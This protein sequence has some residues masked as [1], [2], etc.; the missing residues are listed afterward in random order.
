MGGETKPAKALGYAFS[1]APNLESHH[2]MS[3]LNASGVDASHTGEA[4]PI[5]IHVPPREIVVEQP[6]VEQRAAR[7]IAELQPAGTL[8][9]DAFRESNQHLL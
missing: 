8:H 7:M 6:T 3:A 2:L 5:Q 4:H 1:N 9:G